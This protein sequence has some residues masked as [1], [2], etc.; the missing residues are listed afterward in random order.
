[1]QPC[2]CLL[3]SFRRYASI[4]GYQNGIFHD[5]FVCG[6]GFVSLFRARRKISDAREIL[7]GQRSFKNF[8]IFETFISLFLSTVLMPSVIQEI[9]VFPKKMWEGVGEVLID[10]S[11]SLL[12]LALFMFLLC[13]FLPFAPAY[14]FFD[15]SYFRWH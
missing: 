9:C 15:Q 11:K 10:Y 8:H 6:F 2:F 1:M 14:P 13:F 5:S 3:C 7:F 12:F 4:T